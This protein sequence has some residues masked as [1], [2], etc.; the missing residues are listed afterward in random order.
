MRRHSHKA[1]NGPE[2]T[3]R[4]ICGV[5]QHVQMIQSAARNKDAREIAYFIKYA[6]VICNNMRND[7]ARVFRI[8]RGRDECDFTSSLFR[9]RKPPSSACARA[10]LASTTAAAAM[11]CTARSGA[12]MRAD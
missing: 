2:N 10:G 3:Y 9:K 4:V 5:C 11:P 7:G 6:R 8:G 12:S 1:K